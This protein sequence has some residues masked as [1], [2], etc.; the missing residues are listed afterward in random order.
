[1]MQRQRT[2]QENKKDEIESFIES[3]LQEDFYKIDLVRL[4]CVE[5][6][7]KNETLTKIQ[8]KT[9]GRTSRIKCSGQGVGI[10]HSMFVCLK[11]M[12]AAE[13]PSLKDISLCSFIANTYIEKSSPAAIESRIEII[14][15][16]ENKYGHKTPFR[17]SSTS[18]LKS[19]ALSLISAIQYYINSEK[20][21]VRLRS[22]IA[23]ADRRRRPDIK[24]DLI[25]KITKIVGVSSYEELAL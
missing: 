24:M 15:E 13:Y 3:F 16:F 23:D 22:L 1:M 8:M 4:E 9:P 12:Y 2:P 21:F 17:A 10:M 18:L 19:A 7:K 11:E 6:F 14:V 20:A 5:N 25:Y